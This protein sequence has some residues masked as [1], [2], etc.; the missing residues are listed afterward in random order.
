MPAPRVPLGQLLVHARIITKDVLEEVLA[1]QA[2]SGGKLGAL[3]I[4]RGLITEVQLTQILSHQLSVPWVSL[5]N[6][7]FS[8]ELL[9]LVPPSVA[10]KFLAI[11][12]YL[13][14][15]PDR[16][17]TLYVATDDPLNQEALGMCRASSGRDVRAMIAPTSQV[18]ETIREQ[19][20]SFSKR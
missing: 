7:A 12:I 14:S 2:S 11:P 4:A 16:P 6:I 8:R 13:R 5:A 17:E 10:E 18:R 19:Y 9:A 20:A 3:L 15:E 1:E